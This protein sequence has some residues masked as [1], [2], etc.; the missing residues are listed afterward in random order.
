MS[1]SATHNRS[2]TRDALLLCIKFLILAPICLGIWW[3]L[4][5]YYGWLLGQVSGQ[6]LILLG[7]PITAVR[8]EVQDVSLT[9]LTAKAV[10]ERIITNTHTALTFFEKDQPKTMPVAYMVTNMA[11]FVAL[12]LATGGLGLRRRVKALVIGMLILALGHLFFA[13]ILY[14][15]AAALRD[16]PQLVMAAYAVFHT[17]P[18]LLWVV[19]AYWD[20][21][22]GIIKESTGVSGNKSGN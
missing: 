12:V 17:L 18:F 22:M 21:L 7:K 5:P 20:R 1:L 11:P 3:L 6:I 13:V 8:V 2:L 10:L 9:P 16:Y 4:V 14:A 15:F 19:L